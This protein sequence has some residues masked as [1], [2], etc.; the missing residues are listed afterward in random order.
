MTKCYAIRIQFLNE[1]QDMRIRVPRPTAKKVLFKYRKVFK[2]KRKQNGTI[3]KYKARLVVHGCEQ[4]QGV[5]YEE[6]FA[7][8]ARYETI[9]AFLAGYV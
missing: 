3:D 8:V 9:R 6:I 2:V 7:S 1:V 5:D 4:K